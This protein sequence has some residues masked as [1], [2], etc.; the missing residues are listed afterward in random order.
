M[1]R[2][3]NMDIFDS[4]FEK[5]Q[6]TKKLMDK[7]NYNGL[8][9]AANEEGL[10]IPGSLTD[11]NNRQIVP[12][13]PINELQSN[14]IL[15]MFKKICEH[16]PDGL[17]IGTVSNGIHGLDFLHRFLSNSIEEIS[18]KINDKKIM[19]VYE[20]PGNNLDVSFGYLNKADSPSKVEYIAELKKEKG[21]LRKRLAGSWWRLD[22]TI[23]EANINK[24]S[25][26]F[27]NEYCYSS[28]PLFLIRHCG[29]V[30]IYM[31][32]LCRFEVFKVKDNKESSLGLNSIEKDA[33]DI[34]K[35]SKEVFIEEVK[36][37]NPDVIFATSAPYSVI[38][39][40]ISN[41]EISC[42]NLFKIVHKANQH[43]YKAHRMTV[44]VCYT[45]KCLVEAN[46][47]TP[48]FAG[49]IFL[50]FLSND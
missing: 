4:L 13:T 27:D 50:K 29:L 34:L 38:N 22:E 9:R 8:Y 39:V 33:P 2:V 30:D 7:I 49:D 20:C 14:L 3:F 36:N 1:E 11:C 44:D 10:F 12:I 26:L 6:E 17:S 15:E 5:A 19:I 31:T 43:I 25:Q 42:P 35:Y 37:F 46:V 24:I 28:L 21:N 40:M 32:N 45:L 41:E 16:L 48:K 47:I 18:R 23:G